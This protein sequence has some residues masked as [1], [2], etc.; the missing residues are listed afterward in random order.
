MTLQIGQQAPDFQLQDTTLN[1][2]NLGSFRGENLL[3]L[4]FPLAFTGVCTR[5]LCLVRDGLS[6]YDSLGTRILSI[7]VDS[8]FALAR[9]KEDQGLTFSL[10][11]DFNKEVSALYG[12]LYTDY[13][14]MK[15]VSKRSAFVIDAEGV[16]RY[17]EVLEDDGSLPDFEA[18]EATL[19]TLQ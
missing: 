6:K 14:G 13:F 17:A 19:K 9:F 2:V 18:I 5:E 8:P 15:G 4:F 1:K 7:S 16:V 10:L 12:A 11:S 3:I